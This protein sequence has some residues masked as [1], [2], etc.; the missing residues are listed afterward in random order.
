MLRATVRRLLINDQIFITPIRVLNEAGELLGNFET[1]HAIKMAKERNTD[2]VLVA[3]YPPSAIFANRESLKSETPPPLESFAFDPSARVKQFVFGLNIDVGDFERKIEEMRNFLGLGWR[4]QVSLRPARTQPDAPAR[5]VNRILAEIRDVA[6]PPDIVPDKV[7]EDFKMSI[8]P[9]TRDQAA[10]YRPPV[11][12][13]GL[14]S[15][16]H[17]VDENKKS[18]EWRRGKDPRY[19]YKKIKNELF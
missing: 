9:C 18:R 12:H 5:L 15:A 2:L 14:E 7:K 19:A 13:V 6:K 17:S 11:A 3:A 1:P 10:N 16:D 4:C 8:W